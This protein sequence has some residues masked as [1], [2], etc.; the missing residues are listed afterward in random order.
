MKQSI[1]KDKK[2][3][4]FLKDKAY[5]LIEIGQYSKA[6]ECLDEAIKIDPNNVEILSFKA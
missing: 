6:V 1:E 4:E 2:I 3:A 5:Q